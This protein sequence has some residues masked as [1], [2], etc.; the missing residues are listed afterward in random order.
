M[1]AS[2]AQSVGCTIV[3]IY[4]LPCACVI[5]KKV[6]LSS[7]IRMDDVCTHWKR[8]RFD[9]D[10]IMND[11]KSNISILTEWEVIQERF[12]KAD[13]NMKIHIKE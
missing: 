11:G 3:K 7:P 13:D 5:V 9:D 12:L 6:K 2:I 1:Y 10:G 4:G 8:L